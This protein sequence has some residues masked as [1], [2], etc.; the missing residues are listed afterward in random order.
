LIGE[1]AIIAPGTPTMATLGTSMP[2]VLLLRRTGTALEAKQI[3]LR[4]VAADRDAMPTVLGRIG[5]AIDGTW[6][7][8]D[9][10]ASLVDQVKAVSSVALDPMEE[11]GGAYWPRDLDGMELRRAN[12]HWILIGSPEGP[13]GRHVVA[14][15][16]DKVTLLSPKDKSDQKVSVVHL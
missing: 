16:V 3:A 13:A 2:V 8:V 5:K 14:I 12:N 7:H 15:F 11:S 9:V 6:D 10:P 4:D 1:A